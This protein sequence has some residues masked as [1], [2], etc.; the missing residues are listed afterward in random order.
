MSIKKEGVLQPLNCIISLFTILWDGN[1]G[2]FSNGT[3]TSTEGEVNLCARSETYTP[4]PCYTK[5]RKILQKMFL[6]KH[7]ILCTVAHCALARLR[8]FKKMCRVLRSL[9]PSLISASENRKFAI[10]EIR[11]G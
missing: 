7:C 9:I 10:T 8:L 5:T 3:S 11:E 4:G 6:V 1:W 2:L